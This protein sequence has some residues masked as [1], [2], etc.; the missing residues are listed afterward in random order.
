MEDLE[1]IPVNELIIDFNAKVSP[2][3]LATVLGVNIS[4]IYQEA[5]AGRLPLSIV[6]STYKECIQMYITHFKKNQELK[7]IK[8]QNEQDLKLAR[9][10]ETNKLKLEKEQLR[11]EEARNKGKRSF[12]GEE[13]SDGMHPLMAAKL[14]TDI[15]L[16]LA[17]EKA[18]EQKMAID[19]GEYIAIKELLPL[20]EPYL[21]AIKNNLVDLSADNPEVQ[22]KI[23]EN[24]ESLFNF[25]IAITEK[26]DI[27]SKNFVQTI[28][29]KEL[30][31]S[32]IEINFVR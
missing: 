31:I 5:Q 20:L 30:D 9:I 10:E 29:D 27:D 11:A 26:A 23:E 21:Q 1:N 15:R 2:I 19:R 25:G 17:K 16:G 22:E 13:D 4:L 6:A 14:K 12:G 8:E 18:L 24:M 32:E 7:I 28:L 3:V